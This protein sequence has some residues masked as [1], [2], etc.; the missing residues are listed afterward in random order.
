MQTAKIEDTAKLA[1]QLNTTLID[2]FLTKRAC[3]DK[4]IGCNGQFL[5][6]LRARITR[7][8]LFHH[9]H[10][11]L[12]RAAIV[13]LHTLCLGLGEIHFLDTHQ[14][15]VA[16]ECSLIG[17]F[18]LLLLITVSLVVLVIRIPPFA[19]LIFFAHQRVERLA[20]LNTCSGAILTHVSVHVVEETGILC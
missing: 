16:F 7:I 1:P 12:Y 8:T 9:F 13:A 3:L 2:D 14:D 11:C 5:A 6:T 10:Q 19:T 17:E 20:Y 4:R 15:I 18:K